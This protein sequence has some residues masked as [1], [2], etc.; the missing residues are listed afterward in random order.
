ME[1][2]F[3]KSGVERLDQ[4]LGGGFRKGYNVAVVGGLDGDNVLFLHNLVY[5]LLSQDYRILLVEFRQEPSHLFSWLKSFGIDYEKAVEEGKLKIIDGFSN[6]YFP[7]PIS[8]E[9]NV[10]P[11]PLDLSI[12]TALIRDS[13]VRDSYNFLV[14]DDLS[15][16]YT[17]QADPKVYVRVMV[18]LVNSI[19][20]FGAQTIA[21]LNS[22]V[23]SSKDLATL[24]VPF[25]YV[26]DVRE[27]TA[28]VARSPY[29]L[30]SPQNCFPY[31]KAKNGI[32]PLSEAYEN[33]EVLKNSL[34][35]DDEG[36][37]WLGTE[38]VQIVVE[39]S[40]ASLVEF[41]Y[42][43]LGPEEGERFLYLWGKW[44]FKGY[45]SLIRKKHENLEDALMG[46]LSTTKVLGGGHLEFVQM[47]DE[48]IVLRGKNLF[49]RIERF[50][51]HAHVNYAG[52]IAQ[53]VE[54]FTGEKWE[55]KEVRCQGQG[56]S[57]CEFVIK[58][59]KDKR[60]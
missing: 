50:P 2:E 38:R 15:I 4:I 59:V 55:G 33:L 20:K 18:R 41:V 5:S 31:T 51:Y 42:N 46:L 58:K 30:S 29:P 40:E 57:H 14:L 27:G 19:K 16:L 11:N 44:E 9:E 6:L 60:I 45:G 3:I 34:K 36:N 1:G 22:D 54:D 21:S 23:F 28:K 52:A 49:P 10:L 12:T 8:K 48:L 43:Y 39:E 37:L 56:A 24:L 17:L 26:I 25:E 32:V 7:T 47:T 35:L 13:I 53:F